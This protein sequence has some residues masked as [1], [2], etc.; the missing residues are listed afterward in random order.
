MSNDL[1]GILFWVLGWIILSLGYY[2]YKVYID[3]DTLT[4]SKKL[5]AYRA[6]WNGT[7]SWVGIIVIFVLFIIGCV[8]AFDQWIE[9]KL[10]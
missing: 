10:K 1:I 6:F 3:R 7:L 5:H 9:S 8:L 2:I 4:T